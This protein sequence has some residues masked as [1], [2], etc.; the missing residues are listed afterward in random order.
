MLFNSAV[1]RQLGELIGDEDGWIEEFEFVNQ[2]LAKPDTD[3]FVLSLAERYGAHTLAPGARHD[4]DA[5][6]PL[7]DAVPA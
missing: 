2:T 7:L 1:Y 5:R 6:L 3:R 4:Q